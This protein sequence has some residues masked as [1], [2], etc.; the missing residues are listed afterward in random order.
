MVK[1]YKDSKMGN[2]LAK[3]KVGQAVEV[4]GPY[5]KFLYKPGAYKRIGMIAGG[6]GITPMFQLCREALRDAKG[7]PEMMNLIYCNHRKEDVLLGSELSELMEVHQN[8]A[9]Y[10]VLSDPPRD[11]MGGVGHINKEMIRHFMPPPQKAH[12]SVIL[13]CGPPGFMQAVCGDKDFTV[14]PPS[15]GQLGGMLK[16]LGYPQKMVY[17][18]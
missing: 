13:V 18:F 12:D 2:H 14:S 10:F 3:L 9:P 11:W 4:K 5:D 6:T 17:K 8:F 7:Q 1:Q 15:Q 16:D